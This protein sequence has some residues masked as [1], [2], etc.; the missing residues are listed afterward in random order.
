MDKKDL[1]YDICK[2]I[3]R[4]ETLIERADCISKGET[5]TTK[6]YT[7][8]NA[9]AVITMINGKYI[10]LIGTKPKK[11][12]VT[13]TLKKITTNINKAFEWLNL[14]TISQHLKG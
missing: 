4:T 1:I 3:E 10:S 5:I 7:F 13:R 6:I 12:A 2:L 14:S 11:K 8:Y 9:Y